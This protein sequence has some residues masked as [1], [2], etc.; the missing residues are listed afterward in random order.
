MLP[1]ARELWGLVLERSG[2]THRRK[3]NQEN[4]LLQVVV[5]KSFNDSILIVCCCTKVCLFDFLF[6]RLTSGVLAMMCRSTLQIP[7]TR[8]SVD[9]LI[10]LVLLQ[11]CF[12]V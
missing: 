7:W 11:I 1:G 12:A 10:D 5:L 3:A 4:D 6:V 9:Y 2:F 8:G